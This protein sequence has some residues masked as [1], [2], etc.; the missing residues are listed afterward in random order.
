MHAGR[1]AALELF[2]LIKE[3]T[4]SAHTF[5]TRLGKSKRIL[6]TQKITI[7]SELTLGEQTLDIQS[8]V[9]ILLKF[10]SR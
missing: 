4:A 5:D 8:K 9:I 1:K 7:S 6:P 2:K 3:K 10:T